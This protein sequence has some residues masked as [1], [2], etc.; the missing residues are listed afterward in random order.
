MSS[1][2]TGVIGVHDPD[3][4]QNPDAAVKCVLQ[5]ALSYDDVW[6]RLLDR[7]HMLYGHRAT[8]V[9]GDFWEAFCVLYLETT[10]RY[11]HVW[12]WSGMPKTV[13]TQLGLTGRDRGIDL[14]ARL[15]AEN[16]PVQSS[17]T[18]SSQVRTP[19]QYVA[20]QCK[21]RRRQQKEYRRVSLSGRAITDITTNSGTLQTARNIH[22]RTNW[23]QWREV[24]TF[25]ALCARTGPWTQLMV[26]TTCTGVTRP[27]SMPRLTPRETDCSFSTFQT[28]T[29]AF[30]RQMAGS[31]GYS[32]LPAPTLS[33]PPTA[34]LAVRGHPSSSSSSSNSMNDDNLSS[35][36][37]L[38]CTVV[39]PSSEA[40]TYAEVRDRRAKLFS[41]SQ[42]PLLT[43]AVQITTDF[44]QVA[45]TTSQ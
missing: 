10:G 5:A 43:H 28:T 15:K 41:R 14:V 37:E 42:D 35:V 20:V 7:M 39:A 25:D 45:H 26:M 27:P 36:H 19:E 29:A 16:V 34:T 38:P 18:T 11:E 2:K 3:R 22:V 21:Y 23:L 9:I 33:V 30:W 4:L 24:A 44:T 32:L 1:I 40:L 17:A 12:T 13:R 31:V 8:K 6:S